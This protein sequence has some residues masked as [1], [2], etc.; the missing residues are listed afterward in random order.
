MTYYS[1]ICHIIH[2]VIVNHIV[3]LILILLILHVLIHMA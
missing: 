3:Y 2:M 1:R